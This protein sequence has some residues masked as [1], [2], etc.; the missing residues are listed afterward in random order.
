MKKISKCLN[1]FHVFLKT[2]HLD[3]PFYTGI[4]SIKQLYMYNKYP[5]Q[6]FFKG[7]NSM[8]L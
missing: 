8:I 2:L 4:K 7:S 5:T 3:L 6:F 1:C